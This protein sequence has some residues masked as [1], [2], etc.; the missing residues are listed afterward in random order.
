[1]DLSSWQCDSE[2]CFS[3]LA[4]QE[5]RLTAEEVVARPGTLRGIEAVV[6]EIAKLPAGTRLDWSLPPFDKRLIYPPQETTAQIRRACLARD[7]F[8]YGPEGPLEEAASS[9]SPARKGK[10]GEAIYYLDHKV[11][12]LPD[13]TIRYLRR[14][15]LGEKPP[16]AHYQEFEVASGGAVQT[17]R[18]DPNFGAWTPTRI[19]VGG[20]KYVLEV[21]ISENL[22]TK[23]TNGDLYAWTAAEYERRRPKL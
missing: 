10:Y 3:L 4:H 19:E 7:F 1:M 9:P 11:V 6:A 20:K 12:A 18:T 16:Q 17:I 5:P 2:W 13:F 23:W 21:D 14:G 8:F 22:H 15:V